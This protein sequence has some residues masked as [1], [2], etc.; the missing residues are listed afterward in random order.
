MLLS[1]IKRWLPIAIM[2]VLLVVMSLPLTIF[3][4]PAFAQTLQ[5]PSTNTSSLVVNANQG[6]PGLDTAIDLTSGSTLTITAVG[7]AAFG[8]GSTQNC[9]TTQVTVP[10]GQRMTTDGTLCPPQLDTSAVLPSAPVGELIGSIAQPGTSP[11]AWFA[12]GS[13]YSFTISAPGR[14]FLLYNDDS[15]K[16]RNSNGSYQVIATVTTAIAPVAVNTVCNISTISFAPSANTIQ[17]QG[18]MKRMR[19]NDHGLSS[20]NPLLQQTPIFFVSCSPFSFS[21]VSLG[22]GND[23]LTESGNSLQ[24]YSNFVRIGREEMRD[25]ASR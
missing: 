14:L 11:T 22:G 24:D 12:V 25:Q 2:C 16:Y 4:K 20:F 15:G 10:D 7:M 13:N 19:T 23:V 3:S 21:P 6:L 18:E 8:T 5:Q 9:S 1:A 17:L